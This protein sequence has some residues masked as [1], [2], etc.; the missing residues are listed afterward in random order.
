MTIFI[1]LILAYLLGS[2]PYGLVLV[3][4]FKNVDIRTMGSNNIG[5]TNVFRVGYKKIAF[6]TLFFDIT[7]GALAV[8]LAILLTHN[9]NIAALAGSLATL[10]H[11]FPVWLKFKGGKGVASGFGAVVALN[12]II[13]LVALGVWLLTFFISKFS[14]LSAI[15]ACATILGFG[16]FNIASNSVYMSVA[17]VGIPALILFKHYPNIMRLINKTETK[18]I[19]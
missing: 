2:L 12:P 13:G 4:I 11:I 6:I 19:K 5:F 17:L 3:K 18:L 8:V 14:S 15:F 7:K 9:A 1:T 16:L 10:G